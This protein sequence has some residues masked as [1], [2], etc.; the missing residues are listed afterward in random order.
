[1]LSHML[2]AVPKS[3]SGLSYIYNSFENVNAPSL[4]SG[5]YTF[6]DK[7]FGASGTKLVIIYVAGASSTRAIDVTGAT[8]GGVTATLASKTTV[9]TFVYNI[10][11]Y[12]E[13]TASS[14]DIVLTYANTP[15]AVF[16]SVVSLFDYTSATPVQALNDSTNINTNGVEPT[17]S[18]TPS[19]SGDG[20]VFAGYRAGGVDSGTT[21]TWTGITEETS[22]YFSARTS[23][24]T[25]AAA[26][27]TEGTVSI[28]L[29]DGAVNR[30]GLALAVWK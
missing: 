16:M 30:P 24:L 12:A 18:V 17:L 11:F 29:S 13:V 26:I 9:E 25:D 19:F 14:G 10:I 7:S 23:Q 3:S 20:F 2:R 22:L 4:T 8:I 28:T 6:T 21:S 5:T 1:M 15:N 27:Q